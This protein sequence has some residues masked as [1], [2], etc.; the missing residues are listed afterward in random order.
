MVILMLIP[1]AKSITY[2]NSYKNSYIIVIISSQGQFCQFVSY[3]LFPIFHAGL[4]VLRDYL[5]IDYRVNPGF[6]R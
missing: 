6:R 2:F 1:Y 5:Y 3:F 4:L